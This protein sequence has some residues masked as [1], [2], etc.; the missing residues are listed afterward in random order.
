M[1]ENVPGGDDAPVVVVL[2]RDLMFGS[3]IRSAMATLGLQVVI[4]GD[5]G[6]FLET[7]RTLG[8][9]AVI[10][11]IDMNGKVD[12]EVIAAALREDQSLPPVLGFGS[13]T[14]V[15]T[16]RAAK[17]AGVGRIVSNGQFH[18][19]MTAYVQRYRRS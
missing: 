16:R 12:W 5:T 15:E 10:A 6:A 17:A 8:D 4:K 7:A 13:H 3:R 1:T 2:N 14:D 9:R 18:A 11:I 19:D